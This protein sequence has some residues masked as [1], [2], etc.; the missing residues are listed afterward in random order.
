MV[1]T[2]KESPV[3]TA[4]M[5]PETLDHIDLRSG[6]WLRPVGSPSRE[7]AR[8]D[9]L[10]YEDHRARLKAMVTPEPSEPP[11]TVPPEARQATERPVRTSRGAESQSRAWADSLGIPRHT[12]DRP[13]RTSLGRH[14]A[15]VRLRADVKNTTVTAIEQSMRHHPTDCTYWKA[16]TP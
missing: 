16:P 15:F 5:E 3:A 8:R 9:W 2:S 14:Q 1:T 13:S 4:A 12:K 7:T 10:L 11:P 6:A